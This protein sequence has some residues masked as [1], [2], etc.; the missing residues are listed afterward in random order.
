[1]PKLFPSA[2]IRPA[3]IAH[4]MCNKIKTINLIQKQANLLYF[5]FIPPCCHRPAVVIIIIIIATATLFLTN[6]GRK[7]GNLLLLNNSHW[8]GDHKKLRYIVTSPLLS[9]PHGPRLYVD[10]AP[11][12][13][14]WNSPGMKFIRH[15]C[16]HCCSLF[17][18]LLNRSKH[19]S[20]LKKMPQ[21]SWN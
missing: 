16:R 18:S 4:F 3:Q 7:K 20:Y 9:N 12:K 10:F 5:T 11:I 8:A 15:Y 14:T 2:F 21:Y 17:L 6:K 13:C 1:M 19:F